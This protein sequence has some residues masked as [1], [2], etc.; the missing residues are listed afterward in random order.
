MSSGAL[1]S[2][3]NL[4]LLVTSFHSSTD[5]A[6]AS[7]PFPHEILSKT[8][9]EYHEAIGA[10]NLVSL[11]NTITKENHVFDQAKPQFLVGNGP[12]M[13]AIGLSGP[14]LRRS[15][16]ATRQKS[17]VWGIMLSHSHR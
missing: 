12:G 11:F 13:D 3:H 8:T 9:N 10:F 1:Q 14:R 5:L 15:K 2:G 7:F 16:M 4:F 6:T 17:C